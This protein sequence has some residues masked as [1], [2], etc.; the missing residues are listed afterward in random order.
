MLFPASSERMKSEDGISSGRCESLSR[1]ASSCT[2]G[3]R[4]Q[5][6]RADYYNYFKLKTENPW[7]GGG[8]RGENIWRKLV[9]VKGL[10][11]PRVA[12]LA[13]RVRCAPF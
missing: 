10:A 1:I 9:L 4:R 6:E 7:R 8:E 5:G 13:R 3:P 11:T 12:N 2:R